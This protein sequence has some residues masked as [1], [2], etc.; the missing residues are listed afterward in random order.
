[1]T[2]ISA[3][4]VTAILE[5]LEYITVATVGKDGQPWNSPVYAAFDSDLNFYWGSHSGAQHSKNIADNN[6]VF[7]VIYDSTVPV[8]QGQGVYIQ[9]IAM[10]LETTK[11]KDLAYQVLQNRRPKWFWGREEFNEPTPLGL[12]KAVIEN[13]WINSDGQKDD[14]YIDV[15]TAV[16]LAVLRAPDSH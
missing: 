3:R 2:D 14:H 12:F 9:A 4:Q 6:K 1:M 8:G 16:D 5:K 15:R 10:K 11:E 13:I 7:I